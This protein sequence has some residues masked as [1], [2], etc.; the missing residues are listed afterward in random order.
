MWPV[1]L[2]TR[3]FFF[4]FFLPS[5]FAPLN[6]IQQLED[7]SDTQL[8]GSF[9]LLFV[10]Y[11]HNFYVWHSLAIMAFLVRHSS[12][13]YREFKTENWRVHS[14]RHLHSSACSASRLRFTEMWRI[15]MGVHHHI[16]CSKLNLRIGS[17]P[18]HICSIIE[19]II[20]DD[21]TDPLD[22]FHC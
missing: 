12:L 15:R 2:N 17:G 13:N 21:I 1:L 16:Q 5:L 6:G 3:F 19:C 8:P 4:S 22:L 10:P 14:S 11:G 7:I 18:G 20:M 9:Y